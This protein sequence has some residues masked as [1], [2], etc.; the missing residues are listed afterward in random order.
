MNTPASATVPQHY[1]IYRH[2]FELLIKVAC[3]FATSSLII[4]AFATYFADLNTLW[5]FHVSFSALVLIEASLVVS[6]FALETQV[7][8]PRAIKFVSAVILLCILGV[9]FI[10]SEMYIGGVSQ[11]M[12][13]LFLSAIFIRCL[14]ASPLPAPFVQSKRNRLSSRKELIAEMRKTAEQNQRLSVVNDMI[15]RALLRERQKQALKEVAILKLKLI[16]RAY[17]KHNL[18]M[19][20]INASI[21]G[22]SEKYEEMPTQNE[23]YATY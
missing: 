19:A 6:W 11:P 5:Q 13:A 1:G 18:A 20:Q 3:I 21:Q 8:V 23:E 16:Q 15:D 9:I 14:I 17:A 4:Q 2:L 7:E 12:K 22:I 10:V